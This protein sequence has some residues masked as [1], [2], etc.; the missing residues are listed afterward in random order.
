M[1]CEG[2]FKSEGMRAKEGRPGGERAER[3][4]EVEVALL[5]LL[6]YVAIG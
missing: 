3:S 6:K 5:L 1:G 4:V 2:Y